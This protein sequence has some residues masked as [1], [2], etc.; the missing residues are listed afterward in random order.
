MQMARHMTVRNLLFIA[1]SV[2]VCIVY[3]GP[4]RDLFL[5]SVYYNE[6]YSH[7]V[8]IPFVSAYFIYLKRKEIFSNI[9]YSFSAGIA[10]IIVGILLYLIGMSQGSRLNQND[11]LSFITFSA[12]ITWLGV[13]VFFY[14]IKAFKTAA[15]PLLFL[16]LLVPIP[17]LVID[18]IIL[19][20]QRASSE[21]AAS[22]FTLT[23]VPVLREGWFVFHLPGLSIEVA[24]ECSGIRSSISLFITSIIA[25]Q[26]FL[27]SSWRKVVL[28]LMIFPITIFKNGLR[29]VTLGL[30]GAYVSP[31]I[32]SSNI[33]K[34]GGIPFFILSLGFLGA[35]L[36]LLKRSERKEVPH[37]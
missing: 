10:I 9:G 14:G 23:G 28:T 31:E 34:K 6:L 32:L 13:F 19:I 26:M 30:L 21:V 37:T 2:L 22:I 20:L 35:I 24:K 1:F 8:I 15:F 5:L 25:G 18:N 11:Y 27:N 7:L 16:F 12:V 17:S 3:Y 29:I 36:W 4:F 33:H